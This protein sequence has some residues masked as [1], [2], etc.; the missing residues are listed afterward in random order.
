[1]L[2][3]KLNTSPF[4]VKTTVKDNIDKVTAMQQSQ[5]KELKSF[6]PTKA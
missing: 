5:E 1:V 3:P 6:Q 2:F 4:S